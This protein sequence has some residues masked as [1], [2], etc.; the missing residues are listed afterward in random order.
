MVV[1]G[2]VVDVVWVLVLFGCV[3]F[4]CVLLLFGCSCDLVG[5]CFGCWSCLIVVFGCWCCLIVDVWL[6]VCNY[7]RCLVCNF[8]WLLVFFILLFDWLF[9]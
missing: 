2:L 8:I 3:S 6:L 9:G 4:V 1:D 7:W 5:C